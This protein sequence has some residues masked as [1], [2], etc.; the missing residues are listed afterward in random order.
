[1]ISEH[2]TDH[3]IYFHTPAAE[4][5]TIA[6]ATKDLIGDLL[7]LIPKN[8]HETFFSPAVLGTD[9]FSQLL[10]SCGITLDPN[11]SKL[12]TRRGLRPRGNSGIRIDLVTEASTSPK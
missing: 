9:P 11:H 1:M 4:R 7:N 2:P 6:M 8:L 5:D 10:Q 3:I 12:K